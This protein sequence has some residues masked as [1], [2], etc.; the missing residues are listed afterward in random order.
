MIVLLVVLSSHQPHLPKREVILSNVENALAIWASYDSKKAK[1]GPA[2]DPF[3]I[4]KKLRENI[5]TITDEELQ[6]GT[7]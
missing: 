5:K 6:L 7:Y 4:V 1:Y 3:P 2:A